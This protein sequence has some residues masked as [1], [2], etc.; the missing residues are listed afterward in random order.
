M[1]WWVNSDW[2]EPASGSQPDRDLQVATNMFDHNIGHMRCQ[3]NLE[4]FARLWVCG[5]PKLPETN[6]YHVI[7]SMSAQSGSPAINLYAQYDTNGSPAYL[8]D[9][10]A[11]AVQFTKKYLNDQLIFDYARKLKTINATET[12]T[13]P[14]FS[15][16]TP[17]YTKFLFEGAG[18][19]LCQ[20]T[21]TV[22]QTTGQGSNI[23]AQTSTWLDLRD[24][25]DCYERVVITNSFNGAISN[26]SSGIQTIE[27][28]KATMDDDTN[29]IVF[30]HGIN[31]TVP[32]WLTS[33]DTLFKRLYWSGYRGKFATVHWPCK[34]LP[35]RTHPLDFNLS[36]FYG[37]KSAAA[38]K[39][40]L[41]QLR[42]ERFPNC[43][44]HVYAHSQGAAV[45]SEALSQGAPFDTFVMSQAAMPA[46]CYDTQAPTLQKLLDSE[47][48]EP[49]PDWKVMGY[50]GAHT[51]ITGRCANLFNPQ[52]YALATGTFALLQANWEQNQKVA[53]PDGLPGARNYISDGTN[54]YAVIDVDLYRLVTDSEECRGMVARSRTKAIGALGPATGQTTQGII[55]SAL[56]LNAAFGFFDTRDEHSAEFK[57]NIQNCWRYYDQLLE[58]CLIPQIQRQ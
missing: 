57:R 55:G 52:D 15:D 17:Q 49:T 14:V 23:L 22:S 8:S 16:G 36:E 9:T 24:V 25:K 44:L 29:I 19:G 40:Y 20:L 42:Q 7:L 50:R 6:G 2:D 43:K 53:K 13:L 35:P 45:A 32:D 1:A 34:F 28:P 37:Y 51:N 27:Y 12:Y 47:A 54:G 48:I 26:W 33:S 4:D 5:L 31:N 18:I 56:N 58:E 11:A 39:S 21:L 30:V 10:N 3:R 38:L 46:S 41:N